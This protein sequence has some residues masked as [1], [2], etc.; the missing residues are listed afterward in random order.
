[1]G[2]DRGG[3]AALG[4]GGREGGREGRKGCFRVCVSLLLL[5]CGKGGVCL[6]MCL[7]GE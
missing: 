4:K 7:C 6:C 1:M 3:D 5:C 2:G